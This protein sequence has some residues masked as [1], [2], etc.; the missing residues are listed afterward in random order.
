MINQIQKEHSHIGHLAMERFLDTAPYFSRCG[1]TKVATYIRPRDYAIKKPYMQANRADM[2]SWLVFD[3]DHSNPNVW[4]D[5]NLP[6][7]NFVVRDRNKNTAHLFYAI[8]PVCISNNARKKPVRFMKLVYKAMAKTMDA[9]PSY[10]GVIAKTPHHP[11]WCTTEFHD[12]IYELSE[13]AAH[14]D[15]EPLPSWQKKGKA[16]IGGSRNCTLFEKLRH[17]AYSIVEYDREHSH[18][19]AFKL[20]LEQYA[21]KC[22]DFISQGYNCNLSLSE[23]R[24]TTKSVA[25]WTWEK[26]IRNECFNR[27]IMNL[28]NTLP[29]AH[30]QSLSARRTHQERKFNNAK[31]ILIATQQ[32]VANKEKVTYTAIARLSKLC[33][34]TVTKY[35]SI[36]ER[37]LSRPEIIPLTEI[38]QI[39]KDVNYAVSGNCFVQSIIEP[40]SENN[41][42]QVGVKNIVPIRW[43]KK[44]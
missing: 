19:E 29:Q 18:Y 13:L 22:N 21:E 15:I 3:L 35:K 41:L 28:D 42:F 30:R 1:D 25:R 6:T 26:Y 17:Y 27:G 9:D 12:Y 5:R 44:E 32:I 20:R 34:Q 37:V 8:V 39:K 23:I 16:E 14:V 31:K 7:P 36:I 38:I 10:T 40:G 4:D 24:A 2:I 33:R 11:I 43:F